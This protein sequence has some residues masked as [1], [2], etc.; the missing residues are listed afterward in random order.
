MAERGGKKEQWEDRELKREM[1]GKRCRANSS[2]SKK[3]KKKKE[4]EGGRHRRRR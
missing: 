2:G 4:K 3:T 1:K